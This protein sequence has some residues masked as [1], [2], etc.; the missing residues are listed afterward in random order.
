LWK[1]PAKN[2]EASSAL[3][4]HAEHLMELGII[5]E[6]IPEPLGGAHHDPSLV[7][8]RVSQFIRDQYQLLKR[9]SSELLLEQ[10]YLKFRKMGEFQ[11]KEV[12]DDR[13]DEHISTQELA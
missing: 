2:I 9:I 1:D 10:R 5:D 8:S 6:I 12:S 7:F 13:S 4:L 3:K 11:V